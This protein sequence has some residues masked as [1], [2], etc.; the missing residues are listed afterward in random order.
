MNKKCRIWED[1]RLSHC[2]THFLTSGDDCPNCS[3]LYCHDL[4]TDHRPN[5]FTESPNP[6][7]LMPCSGTG[8]HRK[9]HASAH[10]QPI[11]R[12]Y[13]EN[14][15]AVKIRVKQSQNASNFC[16]SVDALMTRCSQLLVHAMPMQSFLNLGI[17][18]NAMA[19]FLGECRRLRLHG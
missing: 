16:S 8:Q 7:S 19:H 13:T 2:G 9:C 3:D 17:A 12:S 14:A 11:M 15:A 4:T 1:Q 18:M 6:Q 5:L 10:N